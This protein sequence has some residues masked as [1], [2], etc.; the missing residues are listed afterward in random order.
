MQCFKVTSNNWLQTLADLAVRQEQ[1]CE[2]HA[3]SLV[4]QG[5][6]VEVPQSSY[7]ISQLSI[8]IATNALPAVCNFVKPSNK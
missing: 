5:G 1:S 2:Y 8:A 3:C 7:A 6:D 4:R